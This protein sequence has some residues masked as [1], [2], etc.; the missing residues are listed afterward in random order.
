MYNGAR[1]LSMPTP[2]LPTARSKNNT[3]NVCATACNSPP[4]KNITQPTRMVRFL[5]NRSTSGEQVKLPKNAP[6]SSDDVSSPFINGV[7]GKRE[8]K[9]GMARIAETTP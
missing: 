5:L 4:I 2:H 9:Y 7:S 1:Q 6:S 3:H 8:V